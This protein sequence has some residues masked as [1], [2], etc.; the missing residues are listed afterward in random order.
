MVQQE[1]LWTSLGQ[2]KFLT[3]DFGGLEAV[4]ADALKTVCS[5]RLWRLYLGYVRAARFL[6]R[7]DEAEAAQGRTVLAKAFESAIAHVGLDVDSFP[8]WWDYLE[9]IRAQ[10]VLTL[11]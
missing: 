7:V 4:F 9:F 3:C 5:V 2:W 10:P 6:G 8:I 11:S 1:F